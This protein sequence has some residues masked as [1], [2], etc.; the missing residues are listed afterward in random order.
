ML[1][2]I[3]ALAG[4]LAWAVN[5]VL[6]RSQSARIGALSLNAIQYLAAT[7]PFLFLLPFTSTIEALARIPPL[8]MAALLGTALISMV[9]GDTVYVR[10]LRLIGVSKAFP[11]AMCSYPLMS[12]FVAIV[13]LGEPFTWYF[14]IGAALVLSGLFSLSPRH[15][16][17]RSNDALAGATT[18]EPHED[19]DAQPTERPWRRVVAAY[20]R[21][22]QTQGLVCA[23]AAAVC[24]TT[25]VLTLKFVLVEVD[26]LT[27]TAIRVPAAAL[28]LLPLALWRDRGLRVVRQGPRSLAIVGAAGIVGVAL[29]TVLFMAA[30]QNAGAARATILFATSPLFAMVLSFLF[31]KE[32]VTWRTIA[33]TMVSVAGICLVIL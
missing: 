21:N 6:I 5:S 14:A 19:S 32:P 23:L 4:A 29:G 10:S 20:F 27:S 7:L 15:H 25:A 26:A 16:A 31:L 8:L 9:G 17:P 30:I 33:G 2:D 1:G 22:T 12:S 11:I 28:V 3:A 18:A 24:W 13:F